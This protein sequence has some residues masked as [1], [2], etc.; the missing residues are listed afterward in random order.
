MVPLRHQRQSIYGYHNEQQSPS[1]NQNGLADGDLGCWLTDIGVPK[2]TVN[3]HGNKFVLDL[4][5]HRSS[6]TSKKKSILN[7]QNRVTTFQSIPS[8]DLVYRP[9]TL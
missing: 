7:H 9:R 2:K 4:Y 1:R 6:R 3:G 5:K 8:L